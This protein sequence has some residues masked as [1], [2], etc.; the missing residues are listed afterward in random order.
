MSLN[1]MDF[2]DS[3]VSNLKPATAGGF[4]FALLAARVAFTDV[5][6][7]TPELF[8]V[9]T[10]PVNILFDGLQLPKNPNAPLDATGAKGDLSFKLFQA[11][12][13]ATPSL[14][15]KK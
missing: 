2:V 8:D 4:H 1:F 9:L 12:I 15:G 14:V 13:Q 3:E 10:Q 6:S 7:K 5:A 11:G